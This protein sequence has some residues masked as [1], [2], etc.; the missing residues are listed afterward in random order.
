MW[1]TKTWMLFYVTCAFPGQAA[2]VCTSH[3]V[4]GFVS[5][6]VCAAAIP[7]IVETVASLKPVGVPVD[8]HARCVA[9]ATADR[10]A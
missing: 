7:S 2:E 6:R 5:Q 3:S 4:E 8:L 1:L 9:A 10:E